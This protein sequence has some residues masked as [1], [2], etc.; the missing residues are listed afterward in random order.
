MNSPTLYDRL[1]HKVHYPCIESS[2]IAKSL[3]LVSCGQFPVAIIKHPDEK[4]RRKGTTP[5]CSSPVW[6]SKDKNLKPVNHIIFT[7]K[8]RDK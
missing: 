5:N 2:Y 4:Q 8:S 1:V 3:L 6:G 7:V